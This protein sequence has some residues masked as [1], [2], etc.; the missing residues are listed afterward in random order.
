MDLLVVSKNTSISTISND[1]AVCL[2]PTC[3]AVSE[4]WVVLYS[5]VPLSK[6][7]LTDGDSAMFW[8][9]TEH[10]MARDTK[11]RNKVQLTLQRWRWCFIELVLGGQPWSMHPYSLYLQSLPCP[12]PHSLSLFLS[13]APSLPTSLSPGILT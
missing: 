11:L 9:G 12:V 3:V 10:N 5:G 13:L 4:H 1:S 7:L 8:G 2:S 6:G